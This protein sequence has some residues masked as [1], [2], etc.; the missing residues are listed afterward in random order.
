MES[1]EDKYS[2][3][4][5]AIVGSIIGSLII[6]LIFIRSSGGQQVVSG[7]SGY[8]QS[9]HNSYNNQYEDIYLG[10]SSISDRL[11]TLESRIN[12]TNVPIQTN[13][14]SSVPIIGSYKNNEKWLITR[15]KDGFIDNLEVIRD[16]KFNK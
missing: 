14:N 11:K 3:L 1:K 16:A 4:F 5:Y 15:S 13:M 6:Y 10:M 9:I 12:M 2:K 7:S 8:R